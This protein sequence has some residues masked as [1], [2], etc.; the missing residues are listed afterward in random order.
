MLNLR[1][2]RPDVEVVLA[3][4]EDLDAEVERLIPEL[5]VCNSAT[6]KVRDSGISWVEVLAFNGQDANVC[7]GGELSTIEDAG[8]DDMLR[9]V[10]ETER[11][12]S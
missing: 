8:M 3:G 7:L 5:V 12:A 11:L 4:S 6:R 1:A 9:I 2:L 10:D